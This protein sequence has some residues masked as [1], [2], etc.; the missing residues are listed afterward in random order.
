[1]IYVVIAMPFV[2]AMLIL[3][4]H[5]SGKYTVRRIREIHAHNMATDSYVD[6]DFG[7]SLGVMVIDLRKWTY[8]Q[9][10]PICTPPHADCC[11]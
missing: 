1:M 6:Y 7:P 11:A 8:R 5:W 9:F 3:R 10:F 2:Y 4:I